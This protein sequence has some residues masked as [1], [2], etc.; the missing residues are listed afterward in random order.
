MVTEFRDRF[1][2]RHRWA[3]AVSAAVAVVVLAV[4]AYRVTAPRSGQLTSASGKPV[5][6]G[7]VLKV[8][9]LPVT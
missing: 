3:I 4:I 5:P 6:P 8:G 9:A 7:D 2:S 1:T